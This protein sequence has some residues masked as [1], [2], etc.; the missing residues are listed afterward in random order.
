MDSETLKKHR[1]PAG[2]PLEPREAVAGGYTNLQ[3]S[4]F[5]TLAIQYFLQATLNV[6]LSLFWNSSRHVAK[7][8]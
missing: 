3:K 1:A 5:T 2:R 4:Q 6:A 7:I 8:A